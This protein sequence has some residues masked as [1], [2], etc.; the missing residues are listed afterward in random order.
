MNETNP[1]PER[2]RKVCGCPHHKVV[3]CGIAL[4]GVLFLLQGIGILSVSLVGILWP[5]V[6]IVIGGTKL[7][8]RRCNCC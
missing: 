8:G 6:L 1:V 3:P 4:I 2:D 7:M 5:I